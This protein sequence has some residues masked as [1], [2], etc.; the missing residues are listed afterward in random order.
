MPI[1]QELFTLKQNLKQLLKP[2]T[3][4]LDYIESNASDAVIPRLEEL[5][6]EVRK[7]LINSLSLES[8]ENVDLPQFIDL[9]L[10]NSISSKFSLKDN[11]YYSDITEGVPIGHNR[12]IISS[13]GLFREKKTDANQKIE[14]LSWQKRTT[15][16]EQENQRVCDLVREDYKNGLL[17]KVEEPD[18]NKFKAR[19]TLHYSIKYDSFH[20]LKERLLE[21]YT[22]S[23]VNSQCKI[24]DTIS[25]PN[26]IDLIHYT[27]SVNEKIKNTNLIHFL[28]LDIKGAFNRALL[29]Q[30]EQNI[31]YFEIM[32]N[33]NVLK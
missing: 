27:L 20:N 18:T 13:N 12:P 8:K 2:H 4:I 24:L 15:A 7:L 10:L 29:H 9:K 28:T 5:G 16:T 23:G 21:D 3:D 33:E 17:T 14:P 11:E 19:T 26:F 31:M 22:A 25:L 32:D 30:Q 1:T 6:K